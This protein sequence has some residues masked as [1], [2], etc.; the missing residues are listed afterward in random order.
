MRKFWASLAALSL[1]AAASAQTI[2]G[3]KLAYCRYD[4]GT[5]ESGWKVNA[6]TTSGDGFSVDFNADCAGKTILGVCV[7]TFETGV[8][9]SNGYV[10][11]YP[12]N[13]GVDATGA[14][15][16]L[17]SPL[18]ELLHPTGL[19]GAA[20]CGSPVTYDTADVALGSSGVHASYSQAAGDSVLWLCA[21][22]N[23]P[24]AGRSYFTTNN[25]ATPAIPFS[26][27]WVIGLGY[28]RKAGTFLVNGSDTKVTI[29]EGGTLSLD[30][31]GDSDGSPWLGCYV[32]KIGPLTFGPFYLPFIWNSSFGPTPPITVPC[33]SGAAPFTLCWTAFWGDSDDKK[34]NGKAKIKT[35]CNTVA[36]CV[37]DDPTDCGTICACF[38]L[39]DDTVLDATIWKVQNPAGSLDFFNV[40][41]VCHTGSMITGVE[42]ASWDFC[43]SSQS[44]ATVG[45]YAG[46][47]P[48]DPSGNTP[49]TLLTS[50][51]TTTIAP[52]ASD[53]TYPATFYDVTDIPVSSTT[54]YHGAVQWNPGDTCVWIGSDTDGTDDA[55][56]PDCGKIPGSTSFFTLDGY[57]TP[58]ILFT[59]AN[60]M[61][62]IDW[63]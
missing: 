27:N 58:A 41:Y 6:P 42:A 18:A 12:D 61:I 17:G 54:V 29:V 43:G 55:S 33:G 5:G 21:D 32:I 2:D 4:D 37:L 48:V 56:P 52:F 7:E 53:W 35:T 16:D 8:V 40:R 25:Y 31:S 38:G 57:A 15:P 11:I 46:D 62:K 30:L 45:V 13:L 36:V 47:N 50:A 34:K 28:K 63:K 60:W 22:T 51:A 3:S 14:T 26:V 49:G 10:G 44:W 39:S 19:N 9:A 20:G 23:S 59:S 1:A 24:V